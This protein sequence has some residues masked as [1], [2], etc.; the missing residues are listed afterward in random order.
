MA[1][2]KYSIL[3]AIASL[4]RLFQKKRPF[5]YASTRDGLAIREEE[6]VRRFLVART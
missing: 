3:F 4:F 6:T 2:L 1:S 5:R